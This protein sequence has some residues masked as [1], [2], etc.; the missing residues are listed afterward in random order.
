MLSTK[1]DPPPP[2]F[3]YA[4]IS[5]ISSQQLA[6]SGLL[7]L[8]INC[9][10]CANM[11]QHKHTHTTIPAIHLSGLTLF[12]LAEAHHHQMK[13]VSFTTNTKNTAVNAEYVIKLQHNPSPKRQQNLHYSDYLVSCVTPP[14]KAAHQVYA[15]LSDLNHFL[16]QTSYCSS[17]KTV[18]SFCMQASKYSL[19][20]MACNVWSLP[21]KFIFIK[22]KKL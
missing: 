16:S 3:T 22:F 2:E 11:S 5:I 8:C 4:I 7:Q 21:I 14:S 18:F 15:E 10:G 13:P 1:E 20:V 9:K 19:P 17:T 6:W 12:R